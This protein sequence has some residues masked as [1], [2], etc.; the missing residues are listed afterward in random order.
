M[1]IIENELKHPLNDGVRSWQ[2]GRGKRMYR[3]VGDI[4]IQDIGTGTLYR[5]HESKPLRIDRKGLSPD[6]MPVFEITFIG[7]ITGLTVGGKYAKK[8][9]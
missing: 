1:L 3:F 9:D 6:L 7:E 8:R 5:P 4:L 2:S